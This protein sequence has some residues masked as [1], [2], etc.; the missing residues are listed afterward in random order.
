MK[1]QFFK[2]HED[3]SEYIYGIDSPVIYPKRGDKITLEIK[4]N[5][6]K[7]KVKY[8]MID[9]KNNAYQIFV[10]PLTKTT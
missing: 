2:I 7:F 10:I 4:G 3:R 5:N 8:V 6:E 9:Y 1:I